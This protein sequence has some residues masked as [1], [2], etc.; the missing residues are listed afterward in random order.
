MQKLILEKNNNNF[1]KEL[2]VIKQ[3]SFTLYHKIKN[4]ENKI[5]I[6]KIKKNKR[7]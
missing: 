2:K 4:N 5:V 1:S 3:S 7:E 6:K